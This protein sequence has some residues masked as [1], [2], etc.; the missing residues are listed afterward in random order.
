MGATKLDLEITA[1]TTFGPVVIT[2]KDSDA[3]P[4]DLTGW[5]VW[6]QVRKTT[7]GE[8]AHDL[9]PI[10]SDPTAGKI[11]I[12][13]TDEQTA[14]IKAGAFQWDLLLENSEGE[15]LGPIVAGACNIIR[16]ITQ[17]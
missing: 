2:C 1:G 13:Q 3:A 5:T 14:T 16:A 8:I 10:I 11:T 12:A 6:A 9:S 15:R 7:L 4:I 17:P